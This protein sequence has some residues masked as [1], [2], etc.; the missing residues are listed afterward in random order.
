[1]RK[2]K[3]IEL[4]TKYYECNDFKEFLI[5]QWILGYNILPYY[6]ELSITERFKLIQ[7]FIVEKSYNEW[8][9]IVL[10]LLNLVTK[11]NHGNRF[12]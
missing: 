2:N 8:Q 11:R 4:Q 9:D 7:W 1:M 10:Y 3:T 6:L 12:K 5:N